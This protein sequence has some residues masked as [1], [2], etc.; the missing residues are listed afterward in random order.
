MILLTRLV[1][2]SEQRESSSNSRYLPRTKP[3]PETVAASYGSTLIVSPTFMVPPLSTTA[4]IPPL[5]SSS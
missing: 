4:S 2:N 3:L 5:S 1:R